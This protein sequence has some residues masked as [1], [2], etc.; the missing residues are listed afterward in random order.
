MSDRGF[1][2]GSGT[3]VA[4]EKEARRIAGPKSLEPFAMKEY[5]CL[6]FM[7]SEIEEPP[8]RLKTRLASS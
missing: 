6:G 5:E 2:T 7:L 1:R 8:F 3:K 4:L